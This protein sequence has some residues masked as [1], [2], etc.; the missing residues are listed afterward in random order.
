MDENKTETYLKVKTL[1]QQKNQYGSCEHITTKPLPFNFIMQGLGEM[2]LKTE[3]K[4]NDF[5][6]K[7]LMKTKLKHT[8]K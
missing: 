6:N 3:T 8:L 1:Q 2:S 5:Q 4:F 7:T